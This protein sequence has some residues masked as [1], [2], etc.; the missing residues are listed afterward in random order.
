MNMKSRTHMGNGM[1]SH[2]KWEKK[3]YLMNDICQCTISVRPYPSIVGESYFYMNDSIVAL[4]HVRNQFVTLLGSKGTSGCFMAS[5]CTHCG[6]QVSWILCI[7]TLPLDSENLILKRIVNCTF[8]KKKI[9][10][11]HWALVHCFVWLQSVLTQGM[12]MM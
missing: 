5:W 1:A 11:D 8:F 10:F 3:I 12:R 4:C 6:P 7:K 2:G 9:T